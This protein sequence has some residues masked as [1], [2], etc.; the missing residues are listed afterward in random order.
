MEFQLGA[1]VYTNEGEK[2]GEIENVVIDPHS[3]RV[4]HLIIEKGFLFK[5]DKVL[6][7]NL[8]ARSDEEKVVVSGDV[9]S[10]DDLTTYRD[11]DFVGAYQGRTDEV[12][13][14]SYTAPLYYYGSV[15]TWWQ[16]PGWLAATQPRYV[17]K[18]VENLPEN[19]IQ[20]WDNMNI[21]A[22]DEKKVGEV[23]RTFTNP[24]TNEITHILIEQGIFFTED[25]L[26]PTSWIDHVTSDAVH[27]SVPSDYL[28][29]LPEFDED[30]QGIESQR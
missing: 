7:V 5:E 26:V 28:D 21:I 8:V 15:A 27:L 9:T 17:T 18:E 3:G 23:E 14:T 22:S 12:L 20:L 13:P 11:V 2:L 10:F 4:T 30:N 6:P 29:R 25:K 1:D 24:D 16:P 19:A